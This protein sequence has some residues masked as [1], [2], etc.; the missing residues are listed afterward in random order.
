[1]GVSA[2]GCSEEPELMGCIDAY[3]S[4]DPSS[5]CVPTC[6][7]ACLDIL[8]NCGTGRSQTRRVG[9]QAADPGRR[10]AA[11]PRL[12]AVWRQSSLCGTF[13]SSPR[14]FSWWMNPPTVEGDLLYSAPVDLNVDRI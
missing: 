9:L 12:K 10:D 4:I 1:M 13:V 3:L 14:V 5:V 7:P 8:R 6:L 11:A 2:L